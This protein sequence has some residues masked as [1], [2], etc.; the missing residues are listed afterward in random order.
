MLTILVLPVL[1]FLVG[2]VLASQTFWPAD[3]PLF[4]R[5]AY[6]NANLPTSN[7]WGDKAPGAWPQCATANRD[8][9]WAGLIRID[10]NTFHWLGA[11][12][13]GNATNMTSF[14]VTPTR[15]VFRTQA[16]P[17]DMNLTFLTP[18]EPA[19]ISRQ[20]FP[21]VYLYV[22]IQSTDG[23]P[24]DIQMSSD[25]EAQWICGDGGVAIHWDTTQTSSSV[26]HRMAPDTIQAFQDS[27]EQAKDATLYFATP[28]RTGLSWQ[29]GDGLVLR[30][31]FNVSGSFNNSQDP[32]FRHW[33]DR[34]PGMALAL[35]L[36]S[37][38]HERVVWAAGVVRNPSAQYIGADSNPQNR[39]S[40]YWTKFS[41][42]GEAI[43]DFLQDFP[44]ALERADAVDQRII[45]AASSISENY[46]DLVSLVARRVFGAAEV[47][48]PIMANGSLDSS[49]VKI[50]LKDFG[51]SSRM[52]PVESIYAALP[53]ILFLNASLAG[54]FLEPLLDYQSG[55]NISFALSDLGGTFP[56]AAN[57]FQPSEARGV[58][59]SGSMLI[60][61]LAHAMYSGDGS[62]INRYY[63]LLRRWA[64]YLV[65]HVINDPV[66]VTA[67][68]SSI[69]GADSVNLAIKGIIG[70]QAMSLMS[71]VMNV[72]QDAEK[73]STSAAAL[74]SQW[75]NKSFVD[76]RLLLTF[77][78]SS[79]GGLIYDLYAHRLLNMSL[80]DDAVYSGQD[81]FYR[82]QL[83]ASGENAG[84][85]V[86]IASSDV[87]ARLDWTFFTAG[88]TNDSKLRNSF[89][90]L[91]HKQANNNETRFNF[92]TSFNSSSGAM[93]SGKSSPSLGA[94]F[95]LL[96][97]TLPKQAI[98]ITLPQHAS[99]PIPPP[100]HLSKGA[101]AG[102]V[103]ACVIALAA[104]ILVGEVLRRRRRRSQASS[105]DHAITTPFIAVEQQAHQGRLVS[106]TGMLKSPLIF[107]DQVQGTASSSN[108]HTPSAPGSATSGNTSARTW[109]TAQEP[110]DTRS[111]GFGR[112]YVQPETDLLRSDIEALRT[113]MERMRMAVEPPPSYGNSSQLGADI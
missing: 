104:V 55:L 89:I 35:D 29:I 52:N 1:V 48:V 5:A 16:G 90:D 100:H 65:G 69:G 81:S 88:A 83:A 86:S 54:P 6:F 110:L 113:E 4:S 82:N 22:D 66:Q 38:T 106:G 7:L 75:R 13:D 92:A 18:I 99:P 111:G 67:H 31:V 9:G 24:H 70:I 112:G 49:D 64:D 101:I 3:T 19:D 53:A 87:T 95:S 15:S 91:V 76:D 12:I 71:Q 28:L 43:D 85:P 73:Y 96:A 41:T 2:N 107:A 98:S 56:A 44:H 40:Y 77:G 60:M 17:L 93:I 46:P 8:M 63:S 74:F 103:V 84:I 94:L 47:T 109:S 39:T 72:T 20:S 33:D 21:F 108:A 105:L 79:S 68:A 57:I 37:I 26:C 25:M 11:R 61:M 36:G 23:K 10:G 97:L 80:I 30:D 58:E 34:T 51:F 27:G 62:L 14:E 42:I 50:F 59:D 78:N 45:S 32:G 102:I